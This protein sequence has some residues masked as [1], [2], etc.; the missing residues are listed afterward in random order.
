MTTHYKHTVVEPDALLYNLR[1]LTSR[2]QEH[3]RRVLEKIA[4]SYTHS[5]NPEDLIDNET[6]LVALNIGD[7][8]LARQLLRED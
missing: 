8:R 7:I 3:L 1:S 4:D 5:P 2:Q 6:A